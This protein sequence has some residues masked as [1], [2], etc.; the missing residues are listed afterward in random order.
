MKIAP[1]TKTSRS[2]DKDE[3]GDAER[4]RLE[5]FLGLIEGMDIP[6]KRIED[7]RS[8]EPGGMRFRSLKWLDRNIAIRNKDHKDFQRARNLLRLIMKTEWH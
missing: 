4:K 6:L 8:N 2:F 1:I 5:L 3:R 7:V